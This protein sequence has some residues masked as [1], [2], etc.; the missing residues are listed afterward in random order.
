MWGEDKFPGF[1]LPGNLCIACDT[2]T[3]TFVELLLTGGTA[4][5][6]KEELVSL[7]KEAVT[8]SC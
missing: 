6:G 2:Q 4:S 7:Y 3:H 8:L 1:E 5:M